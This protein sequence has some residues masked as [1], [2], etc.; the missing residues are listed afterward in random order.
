MA[1]KN[2]LMPK[3]M[4]HYKA[5][6]EHFPDHEVFAVMLYGSQNYGLDTPDSDVDTKAMVL[7]NVKDLVL[8]RKMVS[9]ELTMPDGALCNVKDVRAMFDNFFKGN[10]NFV[11]CLYTGY[12]VVNPKYDENFALLKSCRAMVA[13]RDP[14]NLM[15]MAAGMAQQKY[16]AFEKPFAGKLDVLAKY[17][18]DPKQLHH[19]ARLRLFMEVF[20]KVGR[21][22]NALVPTPQMRAMLMPYKTN[23]LPYDEAVKEKERLKMEVDEL[24]HLADQRWCGKEWEDTR[25]RMAKEVRDTLD[26]LAFNLLYKSLY[27]DFSPCAG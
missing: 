22:D 17:G 8:G 19:L 14:R 25:D 21:F 12:V 16:V 27:K 23:P 5:V 4:E 15:H 26:E 10:I 7:P 24:L 11:E 18:Y 6:E 1:T 2:E 9:T 3:L 20:L 13:E